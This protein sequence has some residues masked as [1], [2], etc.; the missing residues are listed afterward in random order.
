MHLKSFLI[1][2]NLEMNYY[3]GTYRNEKMENN[4]GRKGVCGYG[5]IDFAY[6]IILVVK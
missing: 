2:W 4:F 6:V 3:F 5:L 1:G